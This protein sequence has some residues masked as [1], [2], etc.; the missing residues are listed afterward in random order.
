MNVIGDLDEDR[1]TESVGTGWKRSYCEGKE[2]QR[3]QLA[4][5]HNRTDLKGT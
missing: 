1:C 5:K 2:T 3:M 4:L